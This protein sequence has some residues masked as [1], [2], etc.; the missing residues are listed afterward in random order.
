MYWVLLLSIFSR[1]LGLCYG[2]ILR[3]SLP[4]RVCSD[5]N[6]IEN[7][8]GRILLNVR[9][10]PKILCYLIKVSTL[11]SNIRFLAS[12]WRL[13]ESILCIAIYVKSLKMDGTSKY[14]GTLFLKKKK[15]VISPFA[16]RDNSWHAYV[17]TTSPQKGL[18]ELC[19]FISMK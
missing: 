10:M 8:I 14:Q 7:P 12:F 2:L 19:I 6:A 13:E 16:F 4:C 11:L 15:N 9:M 3:R 18:I 1:I 17:C 5:K